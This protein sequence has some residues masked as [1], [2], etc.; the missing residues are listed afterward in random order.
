M[1][2]LVMAVVLV[3]AVSSVATGQSNRVEVILPPVF[4]GA[5][6]TIEPPGQAGAWALQ[7]ITR[8]GFEGRPTELTIRSDGRVNAFTGNTAPTVHPDALDSLGQRIRTLTTPQWTVD[9]RLGICS[10]CVATL[11]VLAVRAPNGLVHTY[12]AF[13]DATTK[14][15]VPVDLRRIHD[16]ALTVQ[17]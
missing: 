11:I 17:Q 7:V 6:H 3:G 1:R 15:T 13:W 4:L 16:L 14:S 10:D 5:V 8:G 2:I 9:S 12:T